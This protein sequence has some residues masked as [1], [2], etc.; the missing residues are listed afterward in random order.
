MKISTR[1]RY[2]VRLM[3]DIA[4][5]G[6]EG[7]PVPLKDIARRQRLSRLYLAQLVIPLRNAALVRSVWG[8][9]GG[10]LLVRPADRI[11]LL[12]IVEAVD[13]PICILDCLS[14]KDYCSRSDS[15]EC[16]GL[17][18]EVNAGIVK[19]LSSRTL[20]DLITHKSLMGDHHASSRSRIA[21][22]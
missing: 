14:G 2:A 5:Y 18:R 20:E 9:K 17:W 22:H 11:K 15:C 4:R 19:V 13:G 16:V 8:N 3:A 1:V 7:E 10:F 6:H 12:D 21:A